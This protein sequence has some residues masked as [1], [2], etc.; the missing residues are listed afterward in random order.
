MVR[1]KQPPQQL[2]EIQQR[3]AQWNLIDGAGP[4]DNQQGNGG[5]EPRQ[6][7]AAP[8]HEN[9]RDDIALLLN[10]DLIDDDDNDIDFIP[11]ALGDPAL[12]PREVHW[13]RFAQV[14]YEDGDDDFVDEIDDEV[15][16]QP[17]RERVVREKVNYGEFKNVLDKSQ[18]YAKVSKSNENCVV[19]PR[20]ERDKNNF[21]HFGNIT[22]KLKDKVTSESLHQIPCTEFWVYVSVEADT[23]ALYFEWN[24]EG[25]PKKSKQRKLSAVNFRHYMI[26]GVLD[27]E[28]W[29]GL[30]TQ[31]YFD[32]KLE[33]F[34]DATDEMTL[35]VFLKNGG[36][37]DLKHPSERIRCNES[38]GAVVS[39]FFGVRTFNYTGTKNLKH[40]VEELFSAIKKW[41]SDKEYCALDVQH[42]SLIPQLRPYQK[43]AVKWMLHQEKFTQTKKKS[44]DGSGDLHCLFVEITSKDGVTLYFNRYGGFLVK[45]KP[46]A[47]LPTPGGI[48]ADEMGLGKTV[49]VLSCML[50]HPRQNVEKPAYQE[51]VS[52]ESQKP[53]RK[54]LTGNDIFTLDGEP[55]DEGVRESVTGDSTSEN[56]SVDSGVGDTTDQVKNCKAQRNRTRGKAGRRKVKSDPVVPQSCIKVHIPKRQTEQDKGKVNKSGRPKREATKF[57]CGYASF[58]DDDDDEVDNYK[59]PTKK[60]SVKKTLPKKS[61]Y[62][63]EQEI[64]ESSYWSS[65]ESAIIKECWDGNAKEYKKE[66]SCKEFR[67]FLRMRKKDPCYLM[68]MKERLQIVYTNSMAEYSAKEFVNRVTIQC[69]FD[70]KVAQ[71][72]FFECVCGSAEI[73]SRDEKFR[74]QCSLCS[75]WQHANCV[76]YNMMDPYRGLYICPHCWTQEP[77]VVSGATLI[78]T[79]S[80][81]VYQWVN[82]I[83]KH[84]KHKAIRML[85]YKGVATQGYM[86]PHCLA[87][88]DIVITT[89]ETLSRELNY[90]DLPHSNSQM[91]RRF[92]HPKR[93]MATPSPLPC[94]EWWRVCLDE[95]QMVECTTN[96]TAEMALRLAAINRWCVTGTPVQKTVNE[97]QGLLLFLGV[98]PYWVAQWWY[99]CLYL[100]YCHGI[101][102]PLHDLVAQYM[103]R[104]SKKDVIHQI[105]IPQQIEEVHWLSFT[106]VEEHFY[107]RLHTEC[108]YEA[109]NRLKKFPDTNIKLSSLDR[110]TFN[111]LIQPLLK[112]RQACN[113]PQVVKGQFLSMNRKTMTMEMLLE[114]LIKK[115]KFETEEAH[116]LLIA[117]M[118]GL[119]GIAIIQKQWPQAVDM[120]RNVLRSI[121]EHTNIK[122]D[123][124]QR[125]HTIHNLAEILEAGH[126]GIQPTLRDDS[127][128][129]EA[130]TIR[131][132]YLQ[133][134]PQQV[135]AADLECTQNSKAVETLENNY[136]LG[137]SWWLAALQSFDNDFVLEIRDEILSSYS[138][139]EEHKCLLY[140]VKTRAHLQLVLNAEM[141]KLKDQRLDMI[142]GVRHLQTLD[143][144]SLLDEAI[145]C[146][147]RPM[148]SEPP[149]CLTCATHEFF[150]DYEETLFSMR[151]LKHSRTTGVSKET[152]NVKDKVQVMQATR[153]GDWGQGETE[154]V[155][156]YLQTKSLERVEKEIYEDSQTHFKV[157]EATKKE[158][159]N[160]RILWR[161]VFDT[162]SAMDEVNMATIRLRLRYPDE[163]V[164]KQKKKKDGGDLEKKIEALRYVIKPAELSLQELKLKSDKIIATNDLKIKLG[165]LLYLQNLSKTDFGKDGGKN[166]EPCPICQAE[167][168][169]KWAVLLCCHCYCLECMRT[170]CNRGFYEMDRCTG[171][172]KCP[173][174]RQPT[175]IR[176]ISYVDSKAKEE[177]EVKVQGSLSTKMEGV[178]RLMLKIKLA[179]PGAKVLVFSSWV[180]V[181]NVI[182]DAFAQNG[183]TYR[184]L[185]QHSKF[186]RHLASFKANSQI[187]ALLLPISSG[188]NGLNLIEARHV[189]LVEPILNPAA[190]LQAIGRVHRIGQTKETIVHRFLVRGTIEERMYHILRHHYDARHTDEN[191]VT[192]EDLK[193][194][195]LHSK[196]P[197]VQRELAGN[198]N[199]SNNED[200]VSDDQDN[201]SSSNVEEEEQDCKNVELIHNKGE[202]PSSSPRNQTQISEYQREESSTSNASQSSTS[203][204]SQPSTSTLSQ[205][206]S[207][208]TCHPSTSNLSQSSTSNLSQPSVSNNSQQSSNSDSR[209]SP[210]SVSQQF[211]DQ[212]PH[213]H[214]ITSHH[215]LQQ[216]NI[217]HPST[218]NVCEMYANSVSHPTINSVSQQ[219]VRNVC[220]PSS[221][222]VPQPSSVNLSEP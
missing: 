96:K 119:A 31:R 130:E 131:K 49:E 33:S 77:P 19:S 95:A 112:L 202:Q 197:E 161:A 198:Q 25:R 181:L 83:I 57:V 34:D 72:S 4:A 85:V 171:S 97:L 165:Q 41:H 12:R 3:R 29:Q 209:L 113:H 138:R 216:S 61:T 106:R 17:R 187:T 122:T 78:V 69:F 128:R 141:K 159:K 62:S 68:S 205:S 7:G 139:F 218:S 191:T 124:L 86:Q 6:E 48:L 105:D 42:P 153:R 178:V 22:F 26:E 151:E 50:C 51:P 148:E 163:E 194:L 142:S 39:Y 82:E 20:K 8:P 204:F 210:V 147:L 89:Y 168:G 11:G 121:E 184:A 21:C 207:N 123:C 1:S 206:L 179:D 196:E 13:G 10:D 164:P 24:S 192:I 9:N 45:D 40:N 219:S 88:F 27:V 211:G 60:R 166:L 167:L 200:R 116:R 104:N 203:N 188:A 37:S 135:T 93:F 118:N 23:S 221:D 201:E 193:R 14:R 52:I 137:T 190:E 30:S 212:E 143:S 65:I 177:M 73:E 103:W 169:E 182:A 79:P 28:V 127:L 109:Q 129:E 117:S 75:L 101:K 64:S 36:V 185:H 38:L 91:G 180:D 189:I 140:P 162:V 186:Q 146:H 126:Q 208:I 66:G 133:H 160:Y 84:L 157:W 63:V 173:M 56:I 134:Y 58:G 47:I 32:L 15:V 144:A 99:R 150:E 115:T 53:N 183:I 5:A 215:P 55:Q 145:D 156:K 195:F 132:R 114:N 125:L 120:Y 108:S 111:S 2:N 149:Q 199:Q 100:P 136:N 87:N 71:K 102:E 16:Y 35:N 90:V 158:F 18:F 44:S 222:T 214:I 70:T 170:L 67:K 92:R 54:R 213:S 155:L 175:R 172:V 46:L 80:A 94:V 59:P 43:A 174:C 176:E 74:V 152:K 81:I 110:L 76:Q 154:R 107:Q 217:S 98:D 220:Q